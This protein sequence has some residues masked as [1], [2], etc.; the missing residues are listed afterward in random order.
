MTTTSTNLNSA[1]YRL[2]L[3]PR[4]SKLEVALTNYEYLFSTGQYRAARTQWQVV[5]SLKGAN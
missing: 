3:S 1:E 4:M 5:E 2:A